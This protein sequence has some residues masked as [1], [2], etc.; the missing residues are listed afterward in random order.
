[1]VKIMQELNRQYGPDTV[2][3]VGS[4]LDAATHSGSVLTATAQVTGNETRESSKFLV[5]R[6]ETGLIFNARTTDQKSRLSTLWTK[7]LAKAF[8]HME[9]LQV[10]ADGVMIDLLSHCKSFAETDD[11]TEHIDEPGPLEEA[12]FYFQGEPLRAY[13]RKQ[14]SAQALLAHT[15]V[16]VNGAPVTF[17]LPTEAVQ[18]DAIENF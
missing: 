4:L 1:V 15:P 8:A 18:R 2:T 14:L 17:S 5:F 11:L 9:A 6:I 10:P 3:L 13:M 12:K 16:F 7:I